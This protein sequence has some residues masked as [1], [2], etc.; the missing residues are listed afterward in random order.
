MEFRI[1]NEE[2]KYRKIKETD[3]EPAFGRDNVIRM[4]EE[5]ELRKILIKQYLQENSELRNIK[6]DP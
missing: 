5:Q 3:E 2:K 1:N 4:N 6:Q